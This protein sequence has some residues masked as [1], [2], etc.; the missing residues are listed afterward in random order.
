MKANKLTAKALV[1]S[2]LLSFEFGSFVENYD[3]SNTS[4]SCCS[5]EVFAADT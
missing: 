5:L 1:L 2:N 3:F 4:N